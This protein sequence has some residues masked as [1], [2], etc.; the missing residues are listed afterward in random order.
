VAV[1][2]PTAIM[3]IWAGLGGLVIRA[4][5]TLA[6]HDSTAEPHVRFVLSLLYDRFIRITGI[7]SFIRSQPRSFRLSESV[8]FLHQTDFGVK[9]TRA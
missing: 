3:L 6:F 4:R 2:E 8:Q 1:P 5:H 9:V 7:R